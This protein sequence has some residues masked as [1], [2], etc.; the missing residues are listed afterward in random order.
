MRRTTDGQMADMLV[1]LERGRNVG[2]ISFVALNNILIQ[3]VTSG[4][5][6]HGQQGGLQIG[7]TVQETSLRLPELRSS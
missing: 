3:K 7:L 6:V 2:M 5:L 1:T 4:G